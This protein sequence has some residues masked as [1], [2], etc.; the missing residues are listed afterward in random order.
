MNAPTN[1]K[2]THLSRRNASSLL[3]VLVTIGFSILLAVAA[4]VALFSEQRQVH[5]QTT[6]TQAPYAVT[7]LGTLYGGYESHA[8]GINNSGQVVG[9][10]RAPTGSYLAFLYENGQMKDLG[11]FPGGYPRES[12]ANDINDSGQVVGYG[13][14]ELAEQHAFLYENGQM[15]DLGTFGGFYSRAN[16]I[17]NSGQIVGTAYT[18]D[19]HPHAYLRTDIGGFMEFMDLGTFGGLESFANG[20]NDS[21]KVIGTAKTDNGYYRAFIYETGYMS[22]LGTLPGGLESFANDINNSG[23]IVGESRTDGGYRHAF[24][25]ENSQ[26]KDLGTLPGGL[27]SFTNDINNSGQVV[28]AAATSS[29]DY[30]AYLYENDQMKDLNSLIAQDSGWTLRSAQAIN[31]KGQIVGTGIN[32]DGQTRAFMLTPVTGDEVAP[33]TTAS[34]TTADGN[35]YTPD[36]WTNKDITVGLIA[37]DN[38][39]GSGVKQVTYSVTN[40]D[41]QV[42]GETVQGNEVSVPITSEGTNVLSYY[43]TDNALNTETP[44]NT[45]TIRIDKKAPT[46]E[47]TLSSEPNTSGYYTRPVTAT[48]TATDNTGGSGVKEIVYSI[49]GGS[50]TTVAGASASVP[51]TTEGTTTV[52][53]FAADNAGNIEQAAKAVTVKLDMSALT[54]STYPNANDPNATMGKADLVTATFSR[55]VKGVSEQTFYLKHFTINKNGKETY[56]PVDAKVTTPN[57]IT[58]VLNPTKDLARGTYQATITN[59]VTDMAG[60]PLAGAPYSWKFTVVR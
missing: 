44:H 48:L 42:A 60:I 18:T 29:G 33:T 49:N 51:I 6:P 16:A 21:G 50:N 54:V 38:A 26:M 45:V 8:Y 15:K 34:A 31:D 43:A 12:F 3:A 57:D 39:G 27:E 7:D 30:R 58:A 56:V 36:R 22:D 52:S 40:E 41:Q 35:I 5:A 4:A 11:N 9:G 59:G 55:G 2:R 17:N 37:Q 23:Q 24:L 19:G 13:Y 1:I 14:T 46:T 25:Y 20:L 47:A 32:K 53:Y 28:G 10:A